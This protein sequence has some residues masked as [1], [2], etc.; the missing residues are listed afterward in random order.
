MKKNV[1]LI[2]LCLLHYCSFS[3]GTAPN[4]VYYPLPKKVFYATVTFTVTNVRVFKKDDPSVL[5]RQNTY[6]TVDDPIKVE[7]HMTIGEMQ[8]IDFSGFQKK[9]KN[10]DV[11]LIFDEGGNG[12]LTSFNGTQEPVIADVISGGASILSS[13]IGAVANGIMP[14]FDGPVTDKET[15]VKETQKVEMKKIYDFS[16]DTPLEFE[17]SFID[18]LKYSYLLA[19]SDTSYALHKPKSTPVVKIS[20]IAMTDFNADKVVKSQTEV[21]LPT[22]FYRIPAPYKIKAEISHNKFAKNY[23]VFEEIVLVPQKGVLASVQVPFKKGKTTIEIKFN[24]TT[25]NLEK[26]AVKKESTAKASLASLKTSTD[27]LGTAINKLR[28]EQEER[29]KDTS[30]EDEITKLKLEVEKLQLQKQKVTLQGESQ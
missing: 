14:G 10:S 17:L 11:T 7:S 22:F 3:Q 27:E 4:N 2:L 12:I 26:Y 23:T 6:V 16:N 21:T 18:D 8:V 1:A 29:R 24:T 28:D 13:V 15:I 19:G 20:F 5:L 25:G 9:G 30:L